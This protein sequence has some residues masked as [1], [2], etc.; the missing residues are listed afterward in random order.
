[1]NQ[2]HQ[3]RE[4]EEF[5]PTREPNALPQSR[6]PNFLIVITPI[7]L[8]LIIFLFWYQTWFGRKLADAEMQ[9]YLTDTSVPHKTQHALSQLAE[10]LSRGD[11]SAR[12]WYPQVIALAANK[13][14]GLRLMAAWVM[15]EDNTSPQFHQTL[16][17]LLTDPDTMVRANAALSLVRYGD[18]SGEPELRQM[19]QPLTITAPTSG[20]ISYQ[21][22]EADDLREGAEVAQIESAGAPRTEILSPLPG[23]VERLSVKDGAKVQAG[24]AVAVLEPGEDEVWESL[25]GLGLIGGPEDLGA[26]NRYV[27]GVAGMSERVREQ[28]ALTEQAIR[29]R[30][31]GKDK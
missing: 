12:K 23:E 2:F 25:R 28:A 19:L 27:R 10:Q 15:G 4:G 7:L 17:K 30:A 9:E 1:M 21:V 11:P 16:L 20:T 5:I 3:G 18:A 22:K 6:R 13:E 31:V 14:P 8:V 26:V 29:L 24:D